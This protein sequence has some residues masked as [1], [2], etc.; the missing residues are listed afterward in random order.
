[1]KGSDVIH[2]GR[3]GFFCLYSVNSISISSRTLSRISE[4]QICTLSSRISSNCLFHSRIMPHYA[5]V[6]KN[7][8]LH[9]LTVPW[10]T[11]NIL[12]MVVFCLLLPRKAAFCK[13]SLRPV[14]LLCHF[15][16]SAHRGKSLPFVPH[17]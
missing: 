2:W 16:Q 7:M 6:C 1:M 4:H 8:L 13:R 15:R 17:P 10:Q 14:F 12:V 5:Q 3:I 11:N 9:I